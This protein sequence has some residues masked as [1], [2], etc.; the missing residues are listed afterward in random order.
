MFAPPHPCRFGADTGFRSS[1][2]AWQNWDCEWKQ[3]D[4][5]YT[6]KFMLDLR[7]QNKYKSPFCRFCRLTVQNVH[8]SQCACACVCRRV[9]LW[10]LGVCSGATWET[11]SHALYSCWRFGPWPLL[12]F[13]LWE[14]FYNESLTKVLRNWLVAPQTGSIEVKNRLPSLNQTLQHLFFFFTLYILLTMQHIE[15]LLC[16]RGCSKHWAH[17]NWFNAGNDPLK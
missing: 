17:L 12:L 9:C 15:Y 14:P 13:T 1:G 2:R 10:R 4:K 16:I 5:T 8:A 7:I 6:Y 3:A 11:H